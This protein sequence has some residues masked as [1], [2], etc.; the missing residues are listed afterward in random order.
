MS[1]GPRHQAAEELEEIG[2]TEPTLTLDAAADPVFGEQLEPE[3][4]NEQPLVEAQGMDVGTLLLALSALGAGLGVALGLAGSSGVVLTARLLL[5]LVGTGALLTEHLMAPRRPTDLY[6][7]LL[8]SSPVAAAT[9]AVA[10]RLTGH[11]ATSEALAVSGLITLSTAASL[12][13]MERAERPS[14][15]ERELIEHTLTA[16]SRRVV[17][18][19]T[20]VAEA[21]DLRPGEEIVIEAGDT[22]PVDATIVAGS[23]RVHPWLGARGIEQRAEGDPLLAGAVVAEGRLRAVVGWAGHDRLWMRLTNDPRRRADLVAPMALLGRRVAER[24][25]P[26]AAVA[27]ALVAFAA[28]ADVLYILLAAAATHAALSNPAITQSGALYVMRAVLRALRRGIAFRTADALERASRVTGVAFCARGTLLLGEPE[29]VSIEPFS[30]FDPTRVLALV[31]GAES[32]ATHP[33]AAAILRAARARAVRPDAVRSPTVVPGLGVTAFA[34]TG[35]ELVVGSR[36]LMLRERVAVAKAESKI[37]DLE[38]MGRQVL[39][40]AL[41]GRLVGIVG[42][43]DGLRPGARAA[44][45][46]LLDV[47]VEPVLLSGDARETSEALGRALDIA[48]VRPEVL[49]RE[50]GDEIR[51]I[52]ETGMLV[53]V[54]GRSPVDDIA[55]G[56]ADLSIALRSAGTSTAEWGV[57][58]ASDDVR[59]AALAVRLAHGARRD[60]RLGLLLSATPAVLGTV[61]V[62][63]SLAPLAAAP[64]GAL[65][66]ALITALRLSSTS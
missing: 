48:H 59:D 3:L 25:A 58:L 6:P 27:A 21:E 52:A 20:I 34:S 28:N 33:L 55:L 36:A 66:G 31:A 41:A 42:L 37:A 40:V 57:L 24:G 13:L 26:I 35:E 43:Q 7:L 50:R 29:L 45:Q 15:V 14:D 32:H 64:L 5:A 39:F 46:H 61:A 54:V 9:L 62:L 51:R 12:L 10:A 2:R 38:M 30:G 1:L 65:I 44:V 4:P 49:P 56:A 63:F 11:P 19:E 23:A 17:G 18:T 47:S 60:V 53:A 8:L 16:P 22:V